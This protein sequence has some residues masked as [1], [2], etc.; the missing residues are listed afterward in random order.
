VKGG[1]VVFPSARRKKE[2]RAARKKPKKLGAGKTARQI[3]Q[4]G[5]RF[6]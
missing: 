2:K 5:G 3:P 4:S 1:K 6:L